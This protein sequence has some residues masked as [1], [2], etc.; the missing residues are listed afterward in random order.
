M[1]EQYG[2]Q[3]A[4]V[5]LAIA[6]GIYLT[7]RPLTTYLLRR[8]LF[9]LG[10]WNEKVHELLGRDSE[11]STEGLKWGLILLFTGSGLLTVHYLSVSPDSS[12]FYGI[13][14]VAASLGF[15]LYYLIM[16]TQNKL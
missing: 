12:L 1:E 2:L 7:M 10:Q 14:L 8:R 15:L 6:F 11:S 5:I 4:F 3:G 9:E 13:I 16:R